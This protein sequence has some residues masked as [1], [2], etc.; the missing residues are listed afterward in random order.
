VHRFVRI[1]CARRALRT[2]EFEQQRVSLSDM[3]ERAKKAWHGIK[4]NQPDWSDDSRSVALGAEMPDE[5]LQFHVILNAGEQTLEY[6]LPMLSGA[7][8]WRRWIDTILESPNDIVDWVAAP[9]LDRE[10]YRVGPHS[11]VM[12][13]TEGATA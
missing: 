12:L 5:G 9:P 3:L 11:V 8:A 10:S 6:Q 13:F 7:H 1:L 4:L 2:I